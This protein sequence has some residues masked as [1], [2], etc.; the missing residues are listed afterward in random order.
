M[1]LDYTKTTP[2]AKSTKENI[3]KLDFDTIKNFSYL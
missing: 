1:S 3:A 2:K